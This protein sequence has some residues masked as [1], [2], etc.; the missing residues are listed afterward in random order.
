LATDRLD[1]FLDHAPALIAIFNRHLKLVKANPA[2]AEICHI[3]GV[4]YI[5]KSL[6]EVAAR[7]GPAI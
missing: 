2:F 5:G 3:T 4:D 1:A 6:S 7:L